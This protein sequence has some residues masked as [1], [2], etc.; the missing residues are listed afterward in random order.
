MAW[1]PGSLLEIETERFI[2]RSVTRE[3]IDD[4]FIAWFAD[5]E[6]TLGLNMPA[7]RMTR[8]QHVAYAMNHDNQASFMI[9]VFDKVSGDKVGMFTISY[10]KLHRVAETAVVIGNKSYWGQNVVVEARSALLK[11]IFE[12]L[13]AHKAIGRPH[14]R[15]MSSIFNYKVMG[16]TCEAVLRE[17]MTDA[18]GEGRLDQLI[19]GLLRSDWKARQTEGKDTA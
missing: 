15:N 7:R 12:E 3:D 4:D 18:S 9:L 17:A 8:V 19:F 1:S 6:I 13:N 10:Q 5:P 14:G 11:F 2:L 16:F